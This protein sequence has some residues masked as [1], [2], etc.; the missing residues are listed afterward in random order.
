MEKIIPSIPKTKRAL[1]FE[2]IS[3]YLSKFD[4]LSAEACL[5]AL[6]SVMYRLILLLGVPYLIYQL[7]R[8]LLLS[9]H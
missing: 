5:E 3:R 4:H 2:K 1:L 7:F 6:T 8:F 9:S